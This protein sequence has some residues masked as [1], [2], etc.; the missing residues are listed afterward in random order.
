M[1]SLKDFSKSATGIVLWYFNRKKL[2]MYIKTNIILS[3]SITEASATLFKYLLF[4]FLFTFTLPCFI[5]P[6]LIWTTRITIKFPFTIIWNM[7]CHC[8]SFIFVCYDIKYFNIYVFCFF[9]HLHFGDETWQLPVH[10]SKLIM[11]K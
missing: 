8:F 11:N 3:H 7:F 1:W 5:I 10:L 4:S 6:V 2:N 9:W